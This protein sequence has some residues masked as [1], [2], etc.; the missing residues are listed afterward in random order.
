MNIHKAKINLIIC[1][2]VRVTY[3]PPSIQKIIIEFINEW[4]ISGAPTD[5]C[6]H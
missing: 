1:F 2:S 4:L 3:N 5:C 6:T